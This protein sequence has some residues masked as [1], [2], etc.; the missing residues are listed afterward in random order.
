MRW[1]PVTPG[2]FFH[3]SDADD[4]YKGYHISKNTLIIPL[5]WAIHRDDQNYERPLQFD[6]TRFLG[7]G[8]GIAEGHYG[9]G[10]DNSFNL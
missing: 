5:V 3:Y 9:F 2:S 4:K 7:D 10:L 6:P 8:G 1:M